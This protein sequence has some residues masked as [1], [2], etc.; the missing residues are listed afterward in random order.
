MVKFAIFFLSTRI[1][2]I[3]G[4]TIVAATK[5]L[6]LVVIAFFQTLTIKSYFDGVADSRCA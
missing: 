6:V 5:I 2:I 3:F 4:L 1:I